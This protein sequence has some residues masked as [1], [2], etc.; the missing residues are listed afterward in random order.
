M[1]LQILAVG[2]LKTGPEAALVAHY[3]KQIRW[4]LATHEIADAPENLAK[5]ARQLREA[6]AMRKK[7]TVGS[8]LITL[9]ARGKTLSSEAFAKL[10][11]QY[12]DS[13]R[14]EVAF[15]IGGQDGL[16][17]QLV[18]ESA[19]S[20]SFSPM[21]WPHKLARVMLM[22]Q[23]FRAQCIMHNHPYHGGH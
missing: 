19:L 7:L 10:L 3:A 8:V 4:P 23:I 22:E 21:I 11:A 12:Q 16:H 17:P 5:E 1:R 2:K 20:L 18:K 14:A 15:A 9:D 13:G 6:D